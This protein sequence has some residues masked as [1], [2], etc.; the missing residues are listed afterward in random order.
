MIISKSIFQREAFL[1]G[2]DMIGFSKAEKLE[3]EANFLEQWLKEKKHGDMQWMETNF[4]KRVDPTKLL[5]GTRSVVSLM[6]NYFP[7]EDWKLNELKVSKYAWGRDYHKVI[8]KKLK[9]MIGKLKEE[10]GDFQVR[11]FVDS[12][13]VMD[14]AWA[15]RAGLGWIGK[16]ANL[17][18]KRSGSF[19]FL[20]ELLTDLDFEYDAQKVK[21]YCGNC[22]RCI[23]ACPTKAI[24]SDR[25]I[26]GSKC[27]SY[28]TIEMED[29]IPLEFKDKMNGWAFGCDVCQDVCPWNRNARPHQNTAFKPAPSLIDMSI[30]QWYQ[31]TEESFFETFKGTP[32]MRTKWKGFSRNIQ[33]LSGS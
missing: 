22:T 29:Q 3:K 19:F 6:I 23:D 30:E 33:F 32:V 13:P 28:L 4:D 31:M 12:A 18:N 24:E 5:P 15:E 20:A 21:D 14:R 17:I 11:A 16:N 27:I 1:E 10:I 9:R 8:K 2:F 7:E 25:N 26:N